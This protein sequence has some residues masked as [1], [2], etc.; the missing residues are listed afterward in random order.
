MDLFVLVALVAVGLLVAELLLPTGGGLAAL[1]ALGLV[2]AGVVALTAD[3]DAAA[4]DWAGPGLITLGALCLV[5]SYFV[6]RKVLAAHRGGPVRTGPEELVGASAEART[7]LDPDGQVWIE[8]ALW[9]A[10]LSGDGGPVRPGDRV[11]VEAVEGLTLVVRAE[12]AATAAEQ[13]AG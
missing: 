10:H 13:G 1:G 9:R 6:G 2:G 11:V 3:S 4:S 12:A 5:T 8:G 7:P